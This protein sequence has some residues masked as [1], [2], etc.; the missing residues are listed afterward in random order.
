MMDITLKQ[1]Q[2]FRAVVVAGSIT[3]ASRRVG[4][5]QRSISQQLAKLEERL[6]T[7]LINRNRTGTVNLTPS[8]EYWFKFSDD[9]LRKFEQALSEHEKRYVDNRIVL[10]LGVSPT[11]AGLREIRGDVCADQRRAGGAAAPASA[12]LCYRQ[13][14]GAGRGPQLVRH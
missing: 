5:S 6:G 10:R 11:G 12:Q 3:K 8:G 13:R 4:L 14:R 1:L 7:Q 2:I 9:M